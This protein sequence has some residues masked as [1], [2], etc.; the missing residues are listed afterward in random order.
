[1]ECATREIG[2][3]TPTV[4]AEPRRVVRSAH[5]VA[6]ALFGVGFLASLGPWD[7]F[8]ILTTTLSAWRSDPNPWPLVA[9][10]SLLVGTLAAFATL[11]PRMRPLGRYSA[12]A[13][14]LLGLVAGSA[15][16]IELF[17][18]PSYVVHTPV[19]YVILVAMAG[20][21]GLG[22]LMLRRRMS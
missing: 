8:G 1:V 19:P 5:V 10:I 18:S 16:A 21:L 9:S 22:L 15:T 20:V 17:E 14:P 11:I 2:V 6:V 4:M 7:R 3:S 12:R 13:Y